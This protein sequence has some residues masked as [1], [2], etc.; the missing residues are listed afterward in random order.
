MQTLPIYLYQNVYHVTLDLDPSIRGVN[1]VMYQR[2]LVVQKGFK[3]QIRVQ[4][5]NSDQKKISVSNTQ[6]FIFSMFDYLNKRTVIEK[7]LEILD[8]NTTAT[9]GLAQLTL[10]E[11][12]TI[13]LE[14]SS[15]SFS[16]KLLDSSGSYVPAYSNTYYGINGTI[17]LKEDLVPYNVA[18]KEVTTYT[19]LFNNTTN[20][21]EQFSPALYADPEYNSNS[22]LHTFVFYLTAFRGL[23][24][25]QAT[26]DDTVGVGTSWT[27][28]FE[29][30]YDQFTGLDYQNLNGVYS[31]VRIKFIPATAP[32]GIDNDDPSYY[33][34][35]D[36]ILYRS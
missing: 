10:T 15:Y 3:N 30:N 34:S 35:V 14:K 31:Y 33:G 4:F 1:Q 7:P 6:T 24:T 9:K 5:K 27:T 19:K 28:I 20:L 23:M 12:D 16:I 29:K 11:S 2:D 25:I 8:V 36:K 13:D 21:Y 17:E 26:L 18:S 32:A 22:A